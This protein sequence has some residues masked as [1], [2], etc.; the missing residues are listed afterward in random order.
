MWWSLKDDHDLGTKFIF[1][2]I[3]LELINLCKFLTIV[4]FHNNDV[5]FFLWLK[6]KFMKKLNQKS[7]Q[8][9]EFRSYGKD[10]ICY[11][12]TFLGISGGTKGTRP[13]FT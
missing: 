3:R 1:N 4:D 6:S 11:L 2:S 9:I 5:E 10:T 13:D 12:G 7:N 8:K